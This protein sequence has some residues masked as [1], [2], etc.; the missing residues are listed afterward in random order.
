MAAHRPF[1][2]E[3]DNAKLLG[4]CAGIADH[5]E[6]DVTLVRVAA[7][8]A[9]ALTLPVVLIGYFVL[10]AVAGGCDGAPTRGRRRSPATPSRPDVEETRQRLRD[11][12]ARM[13]AIE[14]EVVDGRNSALAREIDALR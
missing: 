6:I 11:L 2:V 13:Q 7:V 3:R 12:D 10:A 14:S 8:V 1:R 4:V 9:A 5:F